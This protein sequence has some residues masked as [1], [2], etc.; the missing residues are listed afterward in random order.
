MDDPGGYYVKWNKIDKRSKILY[1]LIYV[2]NLK[3]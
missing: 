3:N 2:C 1:D